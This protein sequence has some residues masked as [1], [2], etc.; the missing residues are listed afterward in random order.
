MHDHILVRT[1]GRKTIVNHISEQE[2]R[3]QRSTLSIRDETTS[4]NLFEVC[5]PPPVSGQL[6][7]ADE[8]SFEKVILETIPVNERWDFSAFLDPSARELRSMAGRDFV[9]GSFD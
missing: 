7:W 5:Y 3:A 6:A 2:S 4:S 8:G 9:A 1:L